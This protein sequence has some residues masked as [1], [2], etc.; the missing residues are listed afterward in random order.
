[1]AF[2]DP[3]DR[4]ALLTT[5]EAAQLLHIPVATLRYWRTKGGGPEWIKIGRHVRYTPE[6]L[7]DYIESCRVRAS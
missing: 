4:K 5:D 7:T 3:F 6:A 1:M 2:R